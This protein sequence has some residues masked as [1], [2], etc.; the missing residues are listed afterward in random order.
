MIPLQDHCWKVN[1]SAIFSDVQ[2]ILR[3][4]F[5]HFWENTTDYYNEFAL[6]KCPEFGVLS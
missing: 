4:I 1:V 3:T 5:I 6:T 2:Y